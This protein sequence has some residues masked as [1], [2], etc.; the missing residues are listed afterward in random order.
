MRALFICAIVILLAAAHALADE[1]PTHA[2]ELELQRFLAA[3]ARERAA[4][5]Q[6]E[7]ARRDTAEAKRALHLAARTTE[8]DRISI[9]PPFEIRR[10]PATNKITESKKGASNGKN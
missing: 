1:L 8:A 4:E 7:L 6:L 5:L 2:P 3:S 9:I 10:A